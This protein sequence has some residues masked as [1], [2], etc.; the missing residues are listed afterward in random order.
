MSAL[1]MYF[2]G[3]N[4]EPNLQWSSKIGSEKQEKCKRATLQSRKVCKKKDLISSN[5]CSYP[6]KHLAFLSLH[7]DI[8]VIVEV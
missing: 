5:D 2:G 3:K 6:S 1:G 7:I 4:Q 8:I